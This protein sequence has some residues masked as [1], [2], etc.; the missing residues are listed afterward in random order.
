MPKVKDG[1]NGLRI[2]RRAYDPTA[3]GEAMKESKMACQ[4]PRTDAGNAELIVAL[5]G[6]VLRY[7][8]RQSRWLIW[9]KHRQ[10]WSEDKTHEIRVYAIATA[11]H[12]RKVAAS[13][14]DTEKS[15][16]EIRWSFESEQRHKVDAALELAK[17][18]PPISDPGDGWDVDEWLFGVANGVVDLQTGHLREE[19]P[20]DRIT[21][22]SPVFF[23][24]ATKCPLF[25]RFLTEIFN[26]VVALVTYM[27][28]VVGYCLT[29]S[30]REQCLF[31]WYGSGAN[32]K[33]T[34]SGV[35]RYIF[36]DYAVNLPFS[37]LEMKNR[38][39]N[40]LV[41]L[42]G[43]RFATAAETNEG[44]RL[45]EARIKVLT[46]GDPITARRLYHESFTFDP[47]HKLVLSFNHKPIVADDSEGM[48]RRVRLIPFTKQFMPEDQ[49]KD[50]PGKLV[51]E[52]P[53]I[54]A[55]AVRGCLLW[56]KNGLETPSAVAEATAAYREESDLVGEFIEDCCV[57]ESGVTVA[58]T[59]LWRRYQQWTKD[60]EE[61]SLSRQTFTGRLEKR[62]FRR[63]RSGHGGIRTWVGLRLD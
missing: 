57:V 13:L 32:G 55:W 6:E 47:T 36:G 11:R 53:G 31:C 46:G 8:H 1:N 56:Q 58:S 5:F 7:D 12:R 37:A 61:V 24:P 35:L 50:L 44:V 59:L 2:Y 62:G 33:T 18:L 4:I 45:N 39:S 27:L 51:A 52:A 9:D 49:D 41:S 26:G 60:N 16:Q 42:A 14:A 48:W 28:T 21:K 22:H 38:N 19:R 63:G 23:D 30:V 25:E 34:L 17:S 29:G 15:K 43:S 3:T 20:E 54:L 40:D 10:R